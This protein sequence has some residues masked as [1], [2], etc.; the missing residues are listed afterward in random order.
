MLDS[1]AKI[2]KQAAR[3]EIC[4]RY[5]N[6]VRKLKSDGSVITE[7]DLAMQRYIA[8]EL[9]REWPQ[10]DFLGEEMSDSEHQQLF[11][12]A[13][14]GL[15]VLDPLDGTSNFAAGIPYFSVSLAL[16]QNGEITAGL[17][18]D[19]MRDECFSAQKG[20]GAFLNGEQLKV[21][22]F[23]FPMKKSIALI[24]YKRL[25]EDLRL[26]LVAS[27]PFSSQRSF[28]SV[29]LDW[30]WL[31]CGRG[32]I[33]LHGQQKLWDYAAGYLILKESGGYACTLTG[34]P[35]FVGTMDSRSAVASSDK[36]FFSEWQTWL[37]VANGL[38]A[39]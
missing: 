37:N 12:G 8:S 7:A 26:K 39:N 14:E 1:L 32:H 31:A 29:A 11:D 15:W 22:D 27:P 24:D 21:E 6:V 30:C 34:E 4:P 20:Q 16:V 10:F 33:Y 25:S 13:K 23:S 28:G 36:Q 3:E 35:V 18:Y 17:V 5:N 38:P 19:P 2:V 9:K